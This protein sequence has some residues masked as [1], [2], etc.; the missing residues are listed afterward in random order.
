MFAATTNGFHCD[1]ILFQI[2]EFDSKVIGF[3]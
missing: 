3:E 1:L 2:G